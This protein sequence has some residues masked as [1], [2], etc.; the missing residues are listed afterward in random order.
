MRIR[1]YTYCFGHTWTICGSILG[2]HVTSKIS[3][4][5]N[6]KS[7]DRHGS[8]LNVHC[9]FLG[10]FFFWGGGGVCL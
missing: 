7:R 4:G 9:M 2:F 3:M 8:E 5:V 6:S 1:T 10:C